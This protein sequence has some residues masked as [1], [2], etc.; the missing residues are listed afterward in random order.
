MAY[1]SIA[2]ELSLVEL[3]AG[4]ETAVQAVKAWLSREEGWLLV[5]DNADDPG[6]VRPYLPPTRPG[7]KILLTSRAKSFFKVGIKEPF[8]VDTLNPRTA[9]DFL[10]QR[11]KADA[12]TATELQAVAELATELGY[13][14]LALEQAAA[15][16]ETVGGGFSKYLDR[17]RHQGLALLE[18]GELS[19]DY[20]KTVAT[21]WQLS[22][23]AVRKTSPASAELLTAAAFLLPDSIPI[24]IFTRGGSEFGGLLGM[25]LEGAAE[26]SLTFWEALEPLERFSLVERVQLEA[27]KLHRLTQ[28]VLIH[29]LDQGEQRAWAD[30][31]LKA[32]NAAYPVPEFRNWNLCEKLQPNVR[33]AIALVRSYRLESPEIGRLFNVAGYFAWQRGDHAGA[34][35]FDELSLEIRERVLGAEH[36]DTIC[37]RGNLAETLSALGELA[38][39]RKLQEKNVVIQSCLFWGKHPSLLTPMHTLDLAA[40]FDDFTR[41]WGRATFD[42]KL[43]QFLF[44]NNMAT[45]FW[46][47]E[48]GLREL[49]PSTALTVRKQQTFTLAA[50]KDLASSRDLQEQ[51]LVI[52]EHELGHEHHCTLITR[53][54]LAVVLFRLGDFTGARKLHERN[55]EIRE[56]LLGA[57]H[58]NTTISTWNLLRTTLE[59][60]DPISETHLVDKLRWLLDLEEESIPSADQRIVRRLLLKLLT[61]SRHPLTVPK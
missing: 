20:T 47:P 55:L 46:L 57:E 53:N 21:A 22:F 15:Y 3:Q 59:L 2:R 34:R 18:K 23:D 14:P 5:F 45:S 17:Y 10:I 9:E 40:K 28:K 6:L 49:A 12:Q 42:K 19:T 52:Q 58:P 11:S 16:I 36:S 25:T 56:R 33:A 32:L 31:V 24:E 1:L 50:F 27:F 4:L 8:Q 38:D 41:T 35:L 26:D 39:A 61:P 29:S 60:H 37:S 48:I 44:P 43:D 13:L 30:R 7:G 51:T 54:N